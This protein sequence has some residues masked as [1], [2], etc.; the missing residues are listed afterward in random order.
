M[1]YA[2]LSASFLSF[3][4]LAAALL[5]PREARVR[6]A[7]VLLAA[8]VLLALTA[9]FDSLMI[10]AGLFVYDEERIAGPRIGLA[11][12]E[13]LAYPLAALILLPALWARMR[14]SHDR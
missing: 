14:R 1:T 12:V 6:P 9:V 2:I 4:M 3:S 13:D 8:V 7:P 5:R 11:P 10:A